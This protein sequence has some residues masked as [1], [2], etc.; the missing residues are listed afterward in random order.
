[1]HDY[2]MDF[3]YNYFEDYLWE[4]AGFNKENCYVWSNKI[5]WGQFHSAVVAASEAEKK[6]IWVLIC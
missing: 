2:G 3:F 4:N 6:Y 5:G 1:M